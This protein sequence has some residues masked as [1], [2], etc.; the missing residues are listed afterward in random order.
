MVE[1]DTVTTI[2]VRDELI[3]A[4]AVA[5]FVGCAC[6]I[7]AMVTLAGAGTAAGAV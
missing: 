2:P 4:C 3:S 5:I 1:G 6:E 7:A